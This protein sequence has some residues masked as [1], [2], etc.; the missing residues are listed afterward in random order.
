MANPENLKPWKWK[1]GQSGN[2]SGRPKKKPITDAYERL[3][4][5]RLPKRFRDKLI[6]EGFSVPLK[7]T[8]ADAVAFAQYGKALTGESANAREIR[9]A[10]E[11]KAMQN[12]E[13]AGS[14]GGPLRIIVSYDDAP[15]ANPDEKD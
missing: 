11:G 5:K 7:A 9:E 2:P 6:A 3:A 15:P 14:G 4:K 12:V 13:L 1:P 10:Q 8:F